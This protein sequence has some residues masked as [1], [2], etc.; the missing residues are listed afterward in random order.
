MRALGRTYPSDVSDAIRSTAADLDDLMVSSADLLTYADLDV[1]PRVSAANARLVNDVI[2]MSDTITDEAARARLAEIQGEIAS[3]R[4]VFT[5][6]GMAVHGRPSVPTV[7]ATAT[8][9]SDQASLLAELF[10]KALARYP[11]I[12]DRYARIRPGIE[13]R[14]DLPVAGGAIARDLQA[15]DQ[16]FRWLDD[17]LDEARGDITAMA[18]R[19]L[20]SPS[21]D[22]GRR[23]FDRIRAWIGTL[24]QA[25]EAVKRLEGV[26][27]GTK[28]VAKASSGVPWGAIAAG[29]VLLLALI[30]VAVSD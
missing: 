4:S 10:R 19:A 2:L 20:T 26:A 30:A 25:D 21:V 13:T 15:A 5:A 14:T 29:G 12:V 8:V 1:S 22:I 23:S 28:A 17:N 24:D 9:S 7:E 3:I 11:G 6:N 18:D 27:L 16:A